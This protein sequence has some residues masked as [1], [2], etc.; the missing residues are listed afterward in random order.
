[1][2]HYKSEI[3]SILLKSSEPVNEIESLVKKAVYRTEVQW[4]VLYILSSIIFI[5]W[6][7]IE[8]PTKEELLKAATPIVYTMKEKYQERLDVITDSL[9]EEMYSGGKNVQTKSTGLKTYDAVGS[10]AKTMFNN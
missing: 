3:S 9:E 5:G 8:K 7:I 2:K 10:E 1:M 4:F 6:H